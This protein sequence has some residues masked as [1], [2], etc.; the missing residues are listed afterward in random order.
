MVYTGLPET[1]QRCA[2][3]KIKDGRFL[4]RDQLLKWLYGSRGLGHLAQFK[5]QTR[6]ESGIRTA[7]KSADKHDQ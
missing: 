6:A 7:R 3:S 1:N 2:L 5:F 4:V